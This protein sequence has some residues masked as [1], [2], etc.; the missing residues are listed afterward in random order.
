MKY[1]IL[2]V[3]ADLG[4]FPAEIGL[5]ETGESS[6]EFVLV[7]SGQAAIV[8]LAR[9]PCAGVVVD[10]RLPDMH[11][12]QLLNELRQSR[13]ELLRFLYAPLT[14]DSAQLSQWAT[15]H[16]V[17]AKPCTSLVLYHQLR[18]AVALLQWLPGRALHSLASELKRIPSPPQLYAEVVRELQSPTGSLETV[19]EAIAKDPIMTAK[20]LRMV[21]SAA[22]G[23]QQSVT[24]V[25]SAVMFLGAET[26]K[27]L[28]LISGTFSYF[29]E[30][31]PS[32]LSLKAL[33]DHSFVTAR[34]ARLITISEGL[35]GD[36]A[37]TAYTAGLLH[38]LGKLVLAVNLPSVF[39][40]ALTLAHEQEIPAWK[41][42]KELLGASHA[43]I[44]AALLGLWGLPTEIAQAAA[45]H[46]EPS[47]Q[48][49][50]S[51]ATEPTFNLVTAVHVANV[52]A[53]EGI[54]PSLQS[55]APVIDEDYI[56]HLTL[57]SRLPAWRELCQTEPSAPALI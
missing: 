33:W 40:Q 1:C 26:V 13:P 24:D 14:S 53:W 30:P 18:R 9:R 16:Q 37:T 4:R 5:L 51:H 19:A 47:W 17:V 12:A 52:L 56:E 11:G 7:P 6:L 45:C 8:H 36:R 49:Q 38:D 20:L 44:G 3:G 43:E 46:H 25:G 48:H 10:V 55:V 21:N 50:L 27:S 35:Q 54:G 28:I 42:E 31:R 39:N 34:Y 2:M 29:E 15:E 41:V 22:F 57:T 23:L 32:G